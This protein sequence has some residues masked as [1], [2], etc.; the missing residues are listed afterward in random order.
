MSCQRRQGVRVT[1]KKMTILALQ[2]KKARGEPITMVTA[3]DYPGALAADRAGLD[4][5]LVGD[6]LGMVVL[7]YDSTVPVTMDEMIH[8]CKAVRR[9]ARI[10][11]GSS[12]TCPSCPTRLTG[13][14]RCATQAGS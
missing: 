6:S 13:P 4:T 2:E 8:H 3:Y 11:R 14:R 12:V 10:R 7:G 1:R 9:G 5:I